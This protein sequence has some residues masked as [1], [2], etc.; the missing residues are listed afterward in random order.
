MNGGG[1]VDISEFLLEMI[2]PYTSINYYTSIRATQSIKNNY[3]SINSGISKCKAVSQIDILN[4]AK[5]INY[6]NETEYI[7]EPF[8]IVNKN[9]RKKSDEIRKSLKHKKKP[10]EIIVFTD[11]FSFSATSML[12]KYLQYYGGG[13]V[14][15]YFGNPKINTTFDSSL[16][17]SPIIKIDQLILLNQ[18]FKELKRKYNINLRFAYFQSFTDP[19]NISIP[20]EFSVTPI[21]EKME[22][23]ENFNESNYHIFVEKAKEIFAK[24]Q[25]KCSKINKNLVAFN[26]SCTFKDEKVHGGNP[27]GNDEEWN[28]SECVPSYCDDNYIFDKKTQKCNFD[29]CTIL[30]SNI[31]YYYLILIIIL[32]S[33]LN[34]I[35]MMI[36]GCAICFCCSKKKD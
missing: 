11:G 7:S 4:N 18:N 20:L 25:K 16:S 6:V 5:P 1:F 28:I 24:Y 33:L 26:S 9:L 22:L 8:I 3:R 13:I 19:N 31:Y 32:L 21:D 29:N 14:V 30:E 15:G 34:I 10:T 36:Y 2:S 17:P 35:G 27:C 23:Y 12:I